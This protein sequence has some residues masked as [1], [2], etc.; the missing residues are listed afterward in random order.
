M[1]RGLQRIALSR[2]QGLV[3]LAEPLA[4]DFAPGVPYQ[5]VEGIAP[6]I[7]ASPVGD[8]AEV[9]TPFVVMY[10]GALRAECGVQLLLDSL[11]HLPSNTELWIYG[12]GSLKEKVRECAAQD[13][14]L[15]FFGFQPYEE[16]LA[17]AR[18]ADALVNPRPAT[19]WF[20]RYSFPSK[21]LEYLATGRPVISTRFPTIPA[22]YDPYILWIEEDT[23]EG[24]AQAIRMLQR[25]S[26]DKRA[27]LGQSG[28]EFV[29]R[30]KSEDSQGKSIWRFATRIAGLPMPEGQQKQS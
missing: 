4:T 7:P 11:P 28:R 13:P 29:R 27:V 22:E 30:H 20:T 5:V 18:R 6:D 21:V 2:L 9:S 25:M 14:R 1:D 3:V 10:A 15:K 16:M 23:P 26:P 19:A 8:E 24:F 12:G 17:A